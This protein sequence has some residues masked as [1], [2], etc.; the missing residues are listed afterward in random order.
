MISR[1]KWLSRLS[2]VV[3]AVAIAPE[4]AFARKLDVA[5]LNLN[6]LMGL[7]YQLKV[8]RE[9]ESVAWDSIYSDDYKN[10]RN[11]IVGRAL[12]LQPK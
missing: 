1:R 12:E 7:I 11:E 5:P 6:Y 4:I 9:L 3:A 2:A 8:S 10:W